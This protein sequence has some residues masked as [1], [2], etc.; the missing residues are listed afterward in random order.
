MTDCEHTNTIKIDI[1]VPSFHHMHAI[2]ISHS[3]LCI[4]FDRRKTARCQWRKRRGY[5]ESREFF[6]WDADPGRVLMVVGGVCY[7]VYMFFTNSHHFHL[8]VCMAGTFHWCG[9]IDGRANGLW[10]IFCLSGK[11]HTPAAV[12]PDIHGWMNYI[13]SWNRFPSPTNRPVG[14]WH[15]FLYFLILCWVM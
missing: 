11:T 15:F 4:D 5:I 2:K 14:R 6:F 13:Q 7:V 3:P 10:L 1:L 9:S 8:P 12:N